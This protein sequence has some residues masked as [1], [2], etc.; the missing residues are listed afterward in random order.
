MDTGETSPCLGYPGAALESLVISYGHLIKLPAKK[1][2]LTDGLGMLARDLGVIARP[3]PT[4]CWQRRAMLQSGPARLTLSWSTRSSLQTNPCPCASACSLLRARGQPGAQAPL[5]SPILQ[6]LTLPTL[7]SPGFAAIIH[8]QQKW[9]YSRTFQ[10]GPNGGSRMS[11]AE[12]SPLSR[13][14]GS[15]EVA[16]C[17]CEGNDSSFSDNC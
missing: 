17:D 3:L 1:E 13:M 2:V 8:G 10:N 6:S 14:D 5:D 9:A 11:L 16:R 7:S 4:R 15:A 12:G